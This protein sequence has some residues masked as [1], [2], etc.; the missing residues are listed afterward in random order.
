MP[1]AVERREQNNTS[2][3]YIGPWGYWFSDMLSGGSYFYANGVD[4]R[5]TVE[6]L[7]GSEVFLVAR[8]GP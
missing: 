2:F 6:G 7:S 3:S 1:P 8:K 4:Q 5:C